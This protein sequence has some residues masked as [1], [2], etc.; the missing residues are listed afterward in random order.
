[1]TIPNIA[2]WAVR[3]GIGLVAAG[4]WTHPMW[5]REIETQLEENGNGL[6]K[7]KSQTRLPAGQFTNSPSERLGTSKSQINSKSQIPNPKQ[8]EPLFLLATEVSSIYSQGGKVRRVHILIWVPSLVSARKIS[9]EMTRRGCNLMSDGRPIIGLTSI[10]VAEL[11][12]TIEPKALII[13]AHCLPPHEKILLRGFESKAIS[14]IQSGD[15]VLSHTGEFHEVTEVKKHYYSGELLVIRSW[16]FSS[17]LS[18]T[19]EHPYYAIKTIK[20]C[21][22]TGDICRPSKSH[23]SICRTKPCLRYKPIWIQ[24][25]DLEVGDMLVY[26]RSKSKIIIT[27]LRLAATPTDFEKQNGN[28]IAGGTRGKKLPD[29]IKITKELGRFIGYYLAEGSTDKDNSFSFCFSSKETE[30]IEDIIF[31]AKSLFQL[32]TPRIYR[33]QGTYSLEI[34]FYSKILASW[35][36]RNCYV[37]SEINRAFSKKI[38]ETLLDVAPE[39][40][41]EILRG[42]LR[43]DKGYTSSSVLMNQMKALC[44]KLGII[45]AIFIDSIEHHQ[46]RGNHHYQ[47]RVIQANHDSYFFSTLAF[48]DDIY[49]LRKEVKR[50]QTKI[51]RRHGWIDDEYVYLPV[52]EIKNVPYSGDVHNL[53]VD[54]THSYVAEFAAVHNCWTPWFSVYG[55]LG[56]FDSIE[57]AFGPFAKNIYAVETGLSSNPAMNWRIKELDNRAI[58]SFSDA[59]SGPKL[60]RE[61]TV[62]ETSD[63]L[64]AFSYQHLY[65]AISHQPSAISKKTISSSHLIS[66]SRKLKATI[67]YTI[68]FYPEEGK[69][70][71][72][73]HRSCNIRQTPEETKKKG[74]TCPVCGKQLTVGVMHRV[75]DLASRSEENLQISNFKFQISNSNAEI[76]MIKSNTFPHRPPFVMLVPLQE[77]I[78]EAIGSPVQSPKVQTPYFRLTDA[79]GGEFNVLLAARIEVIAK[80][81][82]ERVA[83]GIEKVRKGDIVIDP[84]YDGVFGVVKIWKEGEEKPLVDSSKEQLSIF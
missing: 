73:G 66:D 69:Y 16:Y 44:L 38:P 9:Q 13:P 34:T 65:E 78:A 18:T 68:E 23:L 82:G 3:K 84:G 28:I 42:W 43:G 67:A 29:N 4:D 24:A 7:L 33:K 63:P 75:E 59:H 61:A 27:S 74:A 35:F 36:S 60:G 30:Y 80:V 21:P 72:T 47:W 17:G 2:A 26:P 39:V 15:V 62:F 46:H 8:D 6:L 45:P 14:D 71:Y 54:T 51:E 49:D 83:V 76:R 79:F 12:L 32:D 37:T 1:M 58:L 22:S 50:P 57:E 5:M 31:L 53:E 81:A 11:V 64:S 70:H 41:A 55:A 48:F 10:Q 25:K 56:G 40:L 52:K 19:P 20:K 77:I